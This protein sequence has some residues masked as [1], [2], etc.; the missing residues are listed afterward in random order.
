MVWADSRP[1]NQ[2]APDSSLTVEPFF[3]L[4]LPSHLP[5][6]AELVTIHVNPK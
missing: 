2:T 1:P 4:W 5:F 3:V 6:V